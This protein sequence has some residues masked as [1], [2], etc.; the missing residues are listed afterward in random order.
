MS[1]KNFLDGQIQLRESYKKPEPETK[2]LLLP[3][4]HQYHYPVPTFKKANDPIPWVKGNHTETIEN[5]YK[6]YEGPYKQYYLGDT[7]LRT[8]P[9]THPV[10]DAAYNKYLNKQRNMMTSSLTKAGNQLLHSYQ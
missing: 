7:K 9:V 8:N 2:Q 5:T 4:Y 6:K 10:E 1:Y 3:G